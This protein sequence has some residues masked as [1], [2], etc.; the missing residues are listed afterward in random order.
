M[1]HPNRL[2]L[3]KGH[4]QAGETELD[5]ALRE[6]VEETGIPPDMVELDPDFRFQITYRYSRY[7]GLEIEKTV[8]IFL[9]WL[10]QEMAIVTSEHVGFEWRLWNP[11]H[12]LQNHTIDPLLSEVDRYFRSKE[13][14]YIVPAKSQ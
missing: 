12:K 7:N 9:G 8:V 6:M 13:N 10:E 14:D 2:D 5:C 3:P 1:H 4:M 11:P